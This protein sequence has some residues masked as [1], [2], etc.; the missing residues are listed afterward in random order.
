M[1][2]DCLADGMDHEEILA[3]YPGLNEEAIRAAI[4]YGAA[5]ARERTHPLPPPG[6]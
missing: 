5:L 3:E 6:R 1:V 2:L 4:A